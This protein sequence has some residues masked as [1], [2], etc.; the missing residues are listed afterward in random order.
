MALLRFSSPESIETGLALCRDI[1]VHMAH[2]FFDW[3][4]ELELQDARETRSAY[5]TLDGGILWKVVE[6]VWN[7]ESME[8]ALKTAN[9]SKGSAIQVYKVQH[10]E[11]TL[12]FFFEADQQM[13]QA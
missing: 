2:G 5:Q 10:G 7:G 6:A 13:I 12:A 3:G 1:S 11:N 9:V 4:A 8:D